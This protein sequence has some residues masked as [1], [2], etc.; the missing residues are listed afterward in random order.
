MSAKH[1]CGQVA[2]FGWEM[3]SLAKA[4]EPACA[5]IRAEHPVSV[6][7]RLH[8]PV[9]RYVAPGLMLVFDRLQRS[10]AR[11]KEPLGEPTHLAL[12]LAR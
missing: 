8:H 2:D 12:G 11:Q 5:H 6:F 1:A 10:S 9:P 7:D 3:D 4:M